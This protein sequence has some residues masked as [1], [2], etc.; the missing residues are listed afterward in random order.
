[1]EATKSMDISTTTGKA[2]C[3]VSQ[4]DRRQVNIKRQ[5]AKASKKTKGAGR[6]RIHP[7]VNNPLRIMASNHV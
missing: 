3:A 6:T 4:D 5:R 7:S 2:L 1:M